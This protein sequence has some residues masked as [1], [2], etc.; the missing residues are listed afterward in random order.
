[1]NILKIIAFFPTLL[2]KKEKRIYTVRHIHPTRDWLFGLFITLLLVV[3]GA[4]SSAHQFMYYKNID[5]QDGTFS[6]KVIT[7]DATTAQKASSMF[8]ERKKIF[9]ALQHTQSQTVPTK[10]VTATTASASVASST[11]PVTVEAPIPA[12]KPTPAS[13]TDSATGSLVVAN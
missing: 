11:K 8:T 13:E 5:T 7:Y 3:T 6:G 10:E 12:P 2:F 4:F 1:M 9:S